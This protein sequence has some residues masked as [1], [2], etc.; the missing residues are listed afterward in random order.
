MLKYK[1][2]SADEY[3]S[4]DT[5]TGYDVQHPCA[6]SNTDKTEFLICGEGEMTEAEMNEY[7]AQNW[8]QSEDDL[9]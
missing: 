7:K 8:P 1:I 2:I 4:T 5:Y 3:N 9:V 6:P